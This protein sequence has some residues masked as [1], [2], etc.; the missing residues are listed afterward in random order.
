MS[1]GC[2]LKLCS[3]QTG[4]LLPLPCLP[5]EMFVRVKS[6]HGLVSLLKS[7]DGVPTTVNMQ[8]EMQTRA[9]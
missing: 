5:A 9:S 2:G 4:R 3:G 1:M 7:R 8:I 6:D